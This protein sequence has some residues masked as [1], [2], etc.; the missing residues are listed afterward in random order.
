MDKKGLSTVVTTLIIILLVLVTVAI[1]WVV[2]KSNS[3]NIDSTENTNKNINESIVIRTLS[4]TT[5]APNEKIDINL[6]VY[7]NVE[8]ETDDTDGSAF[9][10]IVENLSNLIPNGWAIV[11]DGYGMRSEN[12]L[13]W[14]FMTTNPYKHLQ[15]HYPLTYSMQAPASPGT[16]DFTG[17]YVFSNSTSPDG[18]RI[19]GDT[20]LTVI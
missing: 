18:S 19:M 15:T 7:V 1:V 14:I 17:F 16:Y 5:V 20:T 6:D 10:I 9:A 8:L 2:K 13:G 3:S 11:D 4:S 12:T